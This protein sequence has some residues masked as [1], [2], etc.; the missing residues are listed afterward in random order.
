MV[1]HSHYFSIWLGRFNFFTRPSKVCARSIYQH[2][3][4]EEKRFKKKKKPKKQ[5]QTL[6]FWKETRMCDPQEVNNQLYCNVPSSQRVQTTPLFS[7]MTLLLATTHHIFCFFNFNF[8]ILV[9]IFV[10]FVLKRDKKVI[11]NK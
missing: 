3:K 8:K 9:T 11:L 2:T 7:H 4:N 5:K 6:K 10:K 1:I